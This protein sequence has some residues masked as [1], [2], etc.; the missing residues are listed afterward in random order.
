MTIQY[1]RISIME[2]IAQGI[3]L[4]FGVVFSIVVYWLYESF[5]KMPSKKREIE[6]GINTE[7]KE[8]RVQLYLTSYIANDNYGTHT[9][10]Q[11]IKYYD[12]FKEFKD[13]PDEQE[14]NRICTFL[15]KQL[16]KSDADIIKESKQYYQI[17]LASTG[18]PTTSF[19]LN[20]IPFTRTNLNYVDMFEINKQRQLATILKMLDSLNQEAIYDREY[21]MK[22]FENLDDTNRQIVSSNYD[23]SAQ[24][25]GKQSERLADRITTFLNS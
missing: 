3:G 16:K 18:Q 6:K 14:I 10:N 19:K 23:K 17:N 21:L 24:S 25:I 8:L 1:C 12:V 20:Y 22:T 7:F 2:Y 15:E 13:Y 4:F 9:K 11:F 5:I